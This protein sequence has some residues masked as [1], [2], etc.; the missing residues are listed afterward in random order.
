MSEE[1]LNCPFCGSGAEIERGGFG[2]IFAACTKCWCHMGA[3]W[4]TTEAD[5]IAAW[6]RRTNRDGLGGEG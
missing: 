4:S 2:E 6:N 5:A 3:A 1:L